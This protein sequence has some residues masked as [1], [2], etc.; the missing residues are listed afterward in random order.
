[1]W[2]KNL[3]PMRTVALL[4]VLF[5]C[6]CILNVEKC[7]FQQI[8]KLR[9]EAQQQREKVMGSTIYDV[10]KDDK[11]TD[12]AKLTVVGNGVRYSGRRY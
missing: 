5:T 3:L 12:N 1:M 10:E 8:N 7:I 6:V 4:D 9:R 2:K 11:N